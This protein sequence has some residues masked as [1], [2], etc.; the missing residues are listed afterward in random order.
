MAA[1]KD[2]ASGI[3]IE[4]L[5]SWKE[6]GVVVQGDGLMLLQAGSKAEFSRRMLEEGMMDIL[7]SDNHGD[8]RSL[9]T[10]RL[11]LREVG[12]EEQG[13][14]LTETNPA[15]LLSN[16]PLEAVP[17]LGKSRSIWERLLQIFSR[18]TKTKS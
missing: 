14:L 10:V 17:A 15:R 1:V 8:R 12:G 3:T 16:Q 9:G 18:S 11:W 7:A 5:K 2:G 13:R 4:I 6:F